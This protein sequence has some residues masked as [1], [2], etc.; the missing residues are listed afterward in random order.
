[1]G[2]LL[3]AE[4]EPTSPSI[5]SAVRAWFRYLVLGAIVGAAVAAGADIAVP[6]DYTARATILVTPADKTKGLDFGTLQATQA[7][8]PTLSELVTTTPVLSRV[9]SAS[10]LNLDPVKLAAAVTTRVPTG[11][12]LI[13]ISVSDKDANTAAK[14][15][16]AFA[17]EL[18]NYQIRSGNPDA[19]SLLVAL[20]VVDPAT[21]P[22]IRNGPGL[23]VTT[24]LGAA[25]GVFLEFGV[26]YLVDYLRRARPEKL[27]AA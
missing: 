5:V 22:K 8:A 6:P 10:G 26:L 18:V 15:A 17:S 12:S 3:T 27:V 4:S 7:L 21:P 16:N 20:T 25:I 9:M 13:E 19:A 2:M 23:V 11:T 14:L 1:M 24:I